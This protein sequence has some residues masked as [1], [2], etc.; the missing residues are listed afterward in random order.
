MTASGIAGRNE[1]FL[2][3]TVVAGT[4]H[5]PGIEWVAQF[6]EVGWELAMLRDPANIHDG[7][8]IALFAGDTRVGWIPRGDN[9]VLSRLMDAGLPRARHRVGRR[10]A[11]G[12]G[13]GQHGRVRRASATARTQ[14]GDTVWPCPPLCHVWG[15]A[16][17]G[18]QPSS[19]CIVRGD[20]NASAQSRGRENA[21]MTGLNFPCQRGKVA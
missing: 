1:I 4:T 21:M 13:Q 11:Q 7:C 19:S 2:L 6:M 16:P 18:L 5:C 14:A 20:A 10:M 17:S 8:A 12:H 3:E 9:P 15:G